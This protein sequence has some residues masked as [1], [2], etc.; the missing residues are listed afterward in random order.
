MEISW[1]RQDGVGILN[2][3]FVEKDKRSNKVE[4]TELKKIGF[5]LKILITCVFTRC[6]AVYNTPITFP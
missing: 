5:K 6:D 2:R 3:W 1:Y 4:V